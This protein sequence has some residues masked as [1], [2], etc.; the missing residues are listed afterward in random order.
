MLKSVLRGCVK[1]V[2]SAG[3]KTAYAERTKT[4]TFLRYVVATL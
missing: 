2:M 1:L 4:D 3:L